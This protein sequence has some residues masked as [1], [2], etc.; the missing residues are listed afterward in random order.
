MLL[1]TCLVGCTDDLLAPLAE[2]S[3]AHALLVSFGFGQSQRFLF[4]VCM[5]VIT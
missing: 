3:L 4:Q 5:H 2:V 1:T